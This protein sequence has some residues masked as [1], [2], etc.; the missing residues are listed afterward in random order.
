MMTALLISGA[1]ALLVC[2]GLFGLWALSLPMH[3]PDGMPMWLWRVACL[4]KCI[5]WVRDNRPNASALKDGFLSWWAWY[6]PYQNR[7]P[8]TSSRNRAESSGRAACVAGKA[9]TQI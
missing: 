1:T 9:D 7:I 3:I 2:G 5:K 6:G 4:P 8:C